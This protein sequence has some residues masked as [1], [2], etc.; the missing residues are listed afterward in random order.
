MDPD[1]FCWVWLHC[2]DR[3]S[4]SSRHWSWYDVE[5]RSRDN[6]A[7]PSAWEHVSGWVFDLEYFWSTFCH[8]CWNLLLDFQQKYFIY[9]MTH[10]VENEQ[11]SLSYLG[12]LLWTSCSVLCVLAILRPSCLCRGWCRAPAS[13]IPS[14][15]CFRPS[16]KLKYSAFVVSV[17]AHGTGAT[18]SWSESANSQDVFHDL[19]HFASCSCRQWNL[20]CCFSIFQTAAQSFDP[21]MIF[22]YMCWNFWLTTNSKVLHPFLLPC[23]RNHGNLEIS[24]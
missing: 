5:A 18:Y 8:W 1:Y 9:D 19:T 17:V 2:S 24:C 4:G 15:S 13:Q 7:A 6:I 22:G 21:Y 23:N 3:T 12:W 16:S 10:S 20:N 11:L 14:T